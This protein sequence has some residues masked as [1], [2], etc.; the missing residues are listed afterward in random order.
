ME[1][2]GIAILRQGPAELEGLAAPFTEE[3]RAAL[4]LDALELDD[5]TTCG[6]KTEIFVAGLCSSTF[7]LAWALL[8]A[9]PF[10]PWTAVAAA[11]QR[12]GRGQL[13]RP[14]FSPRG[15]LQVSFRLPE[16]KLFY[17]P[18]AAVIM[19]LM[20]LEAFADLGLELCLKWPNDLALPLGKEHGKVGGLLLEERGGRLMAGLGI[21]CRHLPAQTALREDAALPPARLPAGFAP[22]G[23]LPLWDALVRRLKLVYENDFA[24]CTQAS[25][26]RRAETRLLWLGAEV[27]AEGPAG[28]LYGRLS[29]L[30]EQ[31]GLMLSDVDGKGG[32]L[33]IL[34]GGI[35]LRKGL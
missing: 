23:P 25:L 16:D 34:S 3:D 8:E 33:E 27:E 26:L 12:Q 11:A 1:T 7:D 2:R 18:P 15:N 21:N 20:L 13:R 14:W 17:G 29:G 28:P 32:R 31:G 9:G 30:S 19:G 4:E 10:A 35:S 5:L 22:R 24:E 6:A